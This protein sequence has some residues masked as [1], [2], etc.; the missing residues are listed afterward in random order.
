MNIGLVTGEF[1]PMPG[2]V[3]DF[4]RILA[5]QLAGLG[6][7]VHLFSRSGSASESFPLST[8]GAWGP[9]SL[10]RIRSWARRRELDVVNLQFQTAAFDMSPYIHFLPRV[11]PLPLVTT[12]HDLRYPYLF[13]KA[14]PLRNW[15]VMQLAR[16]SA[17]VIATNS[18]DDE[19]LK[20]LRRRKLI[21]IGSNIR[22]RAQQTPDAESKRQEAG[23]NL[24]SFLLGHFGFVSA[25]KGIVPL[26]EAVARLRKA[27]YD[28]RLAFIGARRNTVDSG[29][30]ADHLQTVDKRLRDL[31]LAEVVYW[32]GYLPEDEVATWLR[33]VDLVTLPYQDGASFRRGSLIAALHQGCAVLTTQP[34]TRI[35]AFEQGR[36]LW[37]VP[38][39]SPDAI[40]EALLILMRDRKLLA[41]MRAGARQLSQYFDWD[42]IACETVAFYE[43]CR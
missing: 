1:P 21:P 4:S 30:A 8:T 31:G 38:R 7:H 2:G 24:D 42:R 12:F 19:R 37:L 22:A 23:A 32:T 28:I 14:G 18:E 6:H 9:G 5:E 15:I 3:G 17:G 20:G 33:A 25:G 34:S 10:A 35:D 26:I 43:S 40:A 36:N 27:G 41:G 39:G 13:P 29:E 11:L 16:S